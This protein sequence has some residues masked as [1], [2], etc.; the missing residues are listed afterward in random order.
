LRSTTNND[1][2][3]VDISTYSLKTKSHFKNLSFKKH[4]TTLHIHAK[5]IT[6]KQTISHTS[7]YN[8]DFI[9]LIIIIITLTPFNPLE[10]IFI[11]V[12]LDVIH[13]FEGAHGGTLLLVLVVSV[14]QDG[15]SDK[16]DTA[17]D[18]ASD[19]ATIEA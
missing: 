8:R 18:D 17:D 14:D 19:G 6:R 15:E 1:H 13:L 5:N 11:I 7:L 2:A 12:I 16:S 4:L 3:T 9:S 10:V